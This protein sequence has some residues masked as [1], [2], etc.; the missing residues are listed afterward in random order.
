M[1]HIRELPTAVYSEMWEKWKSAWL[2]AGDWCSFTHSLLL[3]HYKM[4]LARERCRDIDI[5]YSATPA[6]FCH[7][8]TA[9]AITDRQP[10]TG[11]GEKWWWIIPSNLETDTFTTGQILCVISGKMWKVTRRRWVLFCSSYGGGTAEQKLS[12]CTIANL[13]YL[14]SWYCSFTL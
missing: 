11:L 1:E 5:S 9:V 8:S 2:L 10:D 13:V 4:F 12:C 6:H 3:P 7:Y 14:S